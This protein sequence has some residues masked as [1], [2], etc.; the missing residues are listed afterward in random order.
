[1]TNHLLVLGAGQ[2]APALIRDVLMQAQRHDWQV[3]VADR[4]IELAQRRVQDHPRGRCITVDARD[5]RALAKLI[6][7]AKVV[8]NFLAP[9][10]QLPVAKLCVEHRRHMV[11]ASYLDPKVKALDA[12]ASDSGVTLLTEMGLDPGMDHMSVMRLLDRIH[13]DGR[14]VRRFISYGSG[15]PAPED[16]SNP[17]GYA[18]TWNPRN[19]V[20][21]GETGA[22]YLEDGREQIA[23]YPE[24]FRRGWSVDVPGVGSMEAYPN[25]NALK[26]RSVYNIESAQTLIRATMRYPGYIKIWYAIA[27]LGMPNDRIVVPKL[28]SKSFAE[29]TAMFVQTGRASLPDRVAQALCVKP[30][31]QLIADLTWL[32]LFDDRRIGSLGD[33]GG[34]AAGALTLLLSD[35]LRLQPGQKDMV[36]L[37][38]EIEA[39]GPDGDAGTYRS[40]LVHRGE[41]SGITAMARTVGLPSAIA[42][43]LLM[44]DAFP[45]RGAL[46]PTDRSVYE[47]VLMELASYG[48]HFDESAPS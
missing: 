15:V 19:V 1:M 35:R 44:T 23:P 29:L 2:S 4:D 17:L 32:G 26:Y 48:L 14:R 13:G 7:A 25:R 38:H 11:S 12:A 36:I 27:K 43:R 22:M 6:A 34:T 37:H 30:D 3:V 8:V 18:V 5:D 24:V 47:P 28:K 45:R 9:A 46:I 21:A 31:D 42:A 41:P 33:P 10:F 20:M 40:T 39:K 16:R